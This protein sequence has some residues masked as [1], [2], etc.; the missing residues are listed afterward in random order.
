MEPV[1]PIYTAECF[2]PLHQELLSLLRGLSDEDWRRPT[3]AGRWEVRDVVA[4]MLDVDLRKLSVNRDG[5]L[6][7]PPEPIGSYEELVAFL[8]A[9]NAEWVRAAR[10]LS[11]RVLT[12]LLELT[13]PRVSDLVAAL[14]PHEPATFPVSWA[15]ESE[16]ENWFDIGR[17]YTERWHH[18]MQ[19]RAA[20]GAPLLLARRWMYPLLDVS[21]RALP[22]AYRDVRAGDGTAITVRIADESASAWSLRRESGSWRLYRGE[23]T[24]PAARIT[25]DPD[26]AWRVLYNS[27]GSAEAEQRALIDGDASLANPF[28]AIRSVMV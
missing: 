21:L 19:L 16:S 22:H 23:A 6:P 1:S 5:H 4:H 11:P 27:L 26:V 13:G 9:L 14:P 15:G 24:D 8:N 3:M 18:Q 2:P 20:V 28:F 10:R 7:A 25:L 12:E 17:D